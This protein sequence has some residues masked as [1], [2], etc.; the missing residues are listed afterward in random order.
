M[1]ERD[2]EQIVADFLGDNPRAEELAALRRALA[3]RLAALK[4][5]RE[6]LP[7]ENIVELGPLQAQIATMERH[8]DALAVELAVSQF[9]EDTVRAALAKAPDDPPDE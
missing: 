4:A 1:A 2:A 9:T 5:S 3:P 7:P 6:A 8:M